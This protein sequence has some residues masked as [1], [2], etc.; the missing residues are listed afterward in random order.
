MKSMPQAN[1]QVR[2]CVCVCVFAHGAGVQGGEMW[3]GAS[4]DSGMVWGSGGIIEKNKNAISSK[5]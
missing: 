1:T 5:I 2:V 3:L 4:M